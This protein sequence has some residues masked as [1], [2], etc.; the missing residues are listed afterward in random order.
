MENDQEIKSKSKSLIEKILARKAIILIIFGI[1][2][3]F[4]MLFYYYFTHQIDPTRS[5]GDVGLN[6]R[7]SIYYPF[8]TNLLIELFR[9]LSFGFVEVF[10]FWAFLWDLLTTLMFYFVIKSFNIPNKK[11]AFGLF[12][13]NPFFFLNNSF[14][15]ENCGY[16]MTDAF[17]FFFLFLALIFLPKKERKYQYLFYIFLALSMCIKYYTVPIIGILFLKFLY[18]KKWKELKT[19][20]IITIPLIV[21]F[22]V[23]P[24]F[25][26]QSFSE[27]LVEW[28]NIGSEYP[29]PI[30]VLPSVVIFVLFFIFIFK[31]AD[32]LEIIIVSIIAT[33]TF[34]F[35]SYPYLRWFQ[36]IILYGIL[37][38]KEFFSFSLDLQFV[39]RKINVNNHLITFYLSFLGVLASYLMIIFVFN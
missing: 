39:E 8:L 25:Y 2:I 35:F 21:G 27:E 6:F 13:I 18:D 30:R 1:I 16:H 9:F 34:L 37:K 10:A 7:I 23:I 26:S 33:G 3:R 28:Y 31:K 5:W 22:L 36:S 38:Q 11:Y 20:L 19:F 14:S 29:L 17:F 24:F 12:L 15:L 4:G 32:I